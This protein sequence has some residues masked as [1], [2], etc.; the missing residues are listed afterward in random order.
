MFNKLQVANNPQAW[1]INPKRTNINKISKVK[2]LHENGVPVMMGHDDRRWAVF[3]LNYPLQWMPA[4]PSTPFTLGFK[5]FLH[6][7]LEML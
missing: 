2:M 1:K 3:T 5:N 4:P 6:L 7:Q